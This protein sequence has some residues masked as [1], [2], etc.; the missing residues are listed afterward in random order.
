[1]DDWKK[2]LSPGENPKSSASVSF[3]AK[4]RPTARLI[5]KI[6]GYLIPVLL[7]IWLGTAVYRVYFF[8]RIYPGV[9]VLNIDVGGMTKEEAQ[10]AL[11]S[12]SANFYS[13][14]QIIL[15]YDSVRLP[16]TAKDISLALDSAVAADQAYAYG[17]TGG[18]LTRYKQSI[19]APGKPIAAVDA[20]YD[21]NKVEAKVAEFAELVNTP[22]KNYGYKL[23]DKGLTVYAGQ[24]G[25]TVNQRELLG[26]VTA[27]LDEGQFGVITVT[28]EITPADPP[29]WS[30]L[31]DTFYTEPQDAYVE[32]SGN[33]GFRIVPGIDGKDIDMEQLSKDMQES[34]W[35][36]KFYPFIY[37]PHELTAVKL[38]TMLFK[39]VLG[40]S[41]TKL[42]PAEVNRTANVRLSA[43]KAHD[44]VL[45]PGNEFSFN[46]IVGQRTE[47]RG[48]KPAKVFAQGEVV[49]D[50]GGGICQVSSALY[51]ATL[52][53]DLEVTERKT[54]AFAV[55]YVPIGQDATV[56]WG[57]LDYRFVN[58]TS[59]PVRIYAVLE[60]DTL[61]VQILGT[62]ENPARVVKLESNVLETIPYETRRVT[63]AAL[64][65]GTSREI[66]RGNFGYRS[67][68]YQV[69]YEGDTLVEK[70]LAN[71]S[72][73]SSQP[74]IIEYGP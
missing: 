14:K 68:T 72:Y 17:R 28:P 42:N 18:F 33:K 73:Y 23:D 12:Y 20:A 51:V 31:R 37:T 19:S 43:E 9:S 63:N 70:R 59:M 24:Q 53:A 57:Y 64:P 55:S 36:E 50:I 40:E 5:L 2:V 65:S 10:A 8:D 52:T 58:N 34:G 4:R 62:K 11:S 21:R 30:I 67:E 69:I 60:G 48:F 22:H 66:Q 15:E 27:M 71:K 61:T 41:V 1:M 29:D 49:D 74:Q 3:P 38:S 56:Q 25:V 39:D 45:L 44:V 47:A 54:H 32:K 7:L 46:N 35:S 6:V 26:Q 13:G 16:L